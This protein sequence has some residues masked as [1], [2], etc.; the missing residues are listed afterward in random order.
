[1]TCCSGLP[2]SPNAFVR[3]STASRPNISVRSASPRSC[4]SWV[5]ILVLL[6]IVAHHATRRAQGVR[7]RRTINTSTTAKA[8]VAVYIMNAF[9]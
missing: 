9:R 6:V 7:R 8:E 3:F 1:M 4:C 5:S 2:N